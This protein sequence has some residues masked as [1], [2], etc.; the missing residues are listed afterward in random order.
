MSRPEDRDP[1]AYGPRPG[2]QPAPAPLV[3]VV[4]QLAA[5]SD[6]ETLWI[7]HLARYHRASQSPW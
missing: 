6:G 1:P 3:A 7:V 4:G 2:A 5:L